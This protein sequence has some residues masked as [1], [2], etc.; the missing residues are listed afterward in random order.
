MANENKQEQLFIVTE[1]MI[2]QA[3]AY[4]PLADK[5]AIAK[6]VAKACLEPVDAITEQ[7]ATETMI[8][9]PQLYTEKCGAKQ[10]YLMYY[11]LTEY[12]HIKVDGDF[13]E[14]AY[15]YYASNHIFN[16]LE[17]LKV[18]TA[19]EIKD[20]VFNILADYHELERLLNSEVYNQK[21]TLNDSIS[22]ISAGFSLLSTPENVKALNDLLKKTVGDIEVAQKKLADKRETAKKEDTAKKSTK[23]EKAE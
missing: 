17:R 11:F 18:G 8:P 4:L 9:L 1:D 23:T 20:K 5:R 14:V 6:V 22:R 13:D 12:L 21:E 19:K 3:S 10:L 2:T 15:D 7:I 16:Q